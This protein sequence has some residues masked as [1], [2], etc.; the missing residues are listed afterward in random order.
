[1]MN[2]LDFSLDITE[3]QAKLPFM[4]EAS[5]QNGKTS[6]VQGCVQPFSGVT[7]GPCEF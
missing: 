3:V 2:F 4:L 5:E 6:L 7:E 1:M